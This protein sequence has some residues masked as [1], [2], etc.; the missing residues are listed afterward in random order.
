MDNIILQCFN[1]SPIKNLNDAQLQE[2]VFNSKNLWK[3]IRNAD[4]TTRED[5]RAYKSEFNLC[6]RFFFFHR[7]YYEHFKTLHPEI[8]NFTDA[9]R[10]LALEKINIQP[11]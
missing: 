10:Q 6:C 3:W 5:L 4:S 7:D 1:E 2:M 8:K 9:V 11:L